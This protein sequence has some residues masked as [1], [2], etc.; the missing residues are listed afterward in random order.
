M[1]KEGLAMRTDYVRLTAEKEICEGRVAGISVLALQNGEELYRGCFGMA[2]RENR[3]PVKRDT[4]FRMFSMT[5]PVTAAAAYILIERGLITREE[6]VSKYLE[7][8]RNQVVLTPEGTVPVKRECT[9]ADLLN[10]TS[11]LAYPDSGYAAGRRMGRLFDE[12]MRN[13]AAGK[14]IGTIEFVNQI[15]K[16]PLEFHPGEKWRYGASAD[17]LG[18]VIE[19]VSGKRLGSFLR[20][21][22]FEPLGMKDTGFTVTEEQRTRLAVNYDWDGAHTLT[23]FTDAFLGLC[24]YEETTAFESGGAGLVATIDDYAHFAAMLANGGTFG[25]VRI[26]GRKTVEYMTK[27]QLTAEQLASVDLGIRTSLI[28][29]GYTYGNL[30]RILEEPV[31]AGITTTKGEFGW[32]GWTGNYFSVDPSEGYVFLYFIQRCN[33]GTTE[34]AR[35]IKTMCN[36]M[37]R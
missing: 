18:A 36:A 22:I 32:D 14:R 29:T 34:T 5:K 19:I 12:F 10:M 13:N 15:A 7:G 35:R 25:G 17:A 11:G 26:L 24:D 2:D 37:I 6:P 8:F 3:I 16:M 21:E 4:I 1:Q 27:G 33:A 30:M 20:E 9:I 31:S 23:P 28:Q